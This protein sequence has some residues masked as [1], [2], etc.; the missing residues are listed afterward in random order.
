LYPGLLPLALAA[1]GG[2]A[3]EG[4]VATLGDASGEGVES[5]ASSHRRSR[6]HELAR[7]LPLLL[8]ALVAGTAVAAP[9]IVE[10]LRALPTSTR[11]MRGYDAAAS[12]IGS[13]DPWQG[14]EQ[15]LPLAFGRID[16]GGPGAFWG[17]RFHTGNLPLFV[18]LYPGLL[19]LALAAAAG[20]ARRRGGAFAWAAIGLGVFVALGRFNPLLGWIAELAGGSVV[21]FPIKAWLLVAIGLS[22][23]AAAG[24]ERALVLDEAPARRRLRR[25]LLALGALLA[26]G[27]VAA[28][29]FAAPLRAWMERQLNRTNPRGIVAHE[30]MR[31]AIE[32]VAL[33]ALALLLAWVT[34]RRRAVAAD[35][36][37]PGP[38]PAAAFAAGTRAPRPASIAAIALPAAA[39]VLHVGAQL[40]LLAPATMPRDRAAVY[41]RPPSYAALLPAETR[42]A[43]GTLS[44]LFGAVGR[45]P[46]PHG[47]GRWLVRQGQVAGFPLAGVPRR[48][49]YEL[50]RSPEGLDGFLTRLAA[51]ALRPLDDPRRLRLLRTWGVEALLLE[52]P[53]APGIVGA[54]LIA[55]AR[56]PLAPIFL[57]QVI[58]AVP[59]VRRVAGAR[60]AATPRAALVVLLASDFDPHNE[61]VLARGTAAM[62][63][64]SG[65]AIV[66]RSRA[67]SLT[68]RTTDSRAGWVVVQRAWQPHWRAAVDDGAAPVLV[69]DLHRLAVAV[70]AG[71][72]RVRLWVDRTPLHRALSGAVAGLL[73]LLALALTRRRRVPSAAAAAP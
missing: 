10:P 69:A 59:E 29:A 49:R 19:P 66:E 35:P 18:T 16:R 67:E 60:V 21:R 58:G 2:D 56:G 64:G 72:H 26:A 50:A 5:P 61:V 3:G 15:L 33:A 37:A 70:P 51:D 68:I 46:L 43:H 34:S 6:R 14:L 8:L 40:V 65:S 32:C 53:L 52:R 36:Q 11:G 12:T 9:Q 31:W 71:E 24:W 27:A 13:W 25:V 28:A 39:L 23:L 42:L 38:A 62:A 47:E 44:R 22:A 7:W 41:A 1:G 57:Y 45:R 63:P 20:R 73:T 30:P 48:W 55:Q 17:H 54:P 4:S